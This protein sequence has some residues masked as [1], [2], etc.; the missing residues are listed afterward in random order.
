MIHT[1]EGIQN[2]KYSGKR[3]QPLPN[4]WL[5]DLP[6]PGQDFFRESRGESDVLDRSAP[7]LQ[8]D[9][10]AGMLQEIKHGPVPPLDRREMDPRPAD[11]PQQGVIHIA[12]LDILSLDPPSEQPELQFQTLRIQPDDKLSI[13]QKIE[14]EKTEVREEEY[15]QEIDPPIDESP[16]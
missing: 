3:T 7:F 1:D 2:C 16:N 5:P 9:H 15:R 14:G 6:D 12:V 8:P 10:Q 11:P 13:I 4:K